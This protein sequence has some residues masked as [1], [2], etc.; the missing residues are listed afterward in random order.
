[1][2]VHAIIIQMLLQ[3]LK[4]IK[5]VQTTYKHSEIA[6]LLRD[7]VCLHDL[8]CSFNKSMLLQT[9]VTYIY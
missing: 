7:N 8:L 1:M 6:Y 3:L 4:N 2:Y 9:L 5:R